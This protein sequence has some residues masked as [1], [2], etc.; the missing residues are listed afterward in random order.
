MGPVTA[1]RVV[2]IQVAGV[3]VLAADNVLS[4]TSLF[5]LQCAASETINSCF[6]VC[7][8]AYVQVKDETELY[9]STVNSFGKNAFQLGKQKPQT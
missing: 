1:T 2:S 9:Y 7:S 5:G 8:L 3:C 6:C 4:Q